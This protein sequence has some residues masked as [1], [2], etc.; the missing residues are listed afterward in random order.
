MKKLL[1]I[2]PYLTMVWVAMYVSK[3]T[4]EIRWES[5]SRW[6]T[7]K[8]CMKAAKK[9]KKDSTGDYYYL[10]EHKFVPP[11]AKRPSEYKPICYRLTKYSTR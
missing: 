10:P 2:L 5:K 8:Q 3:D 7:K 9:L 4:G 6:T 1:R 11:W